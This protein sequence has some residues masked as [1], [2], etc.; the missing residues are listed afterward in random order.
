MHKVPISPHP[1]WYPCW[2]YFPLENYICTCA[3]EVVSHCDL[4]DDYSCWAAFDVCGGHAYISFGEMS[5]QVHGAVFNWSFCLLLLS[6]K[7]SSPMLDNNVY[8]IYDL[9]IFVHILWV[10]LLLSFF[11]HFLIVFQVWL[12]PFSPHHSPLPSSHPHFSPLILTPLVLSMCPL[13]MFLKTLPFSP[14]IPSHLPSGHC[15]FVLFFF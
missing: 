2:Y 6:C 13:Y 7:N 14:V 12:S 5:I 15:Q 1:C 8:Q 3:Y 9:H 10:L 11:P 4:P